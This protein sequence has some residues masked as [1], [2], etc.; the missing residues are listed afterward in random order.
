MTPPNLGQSLSILL[1]IEDDNEL[2]GLTCPATGLPVWPLIRVAVLRTIMSDWLF[3][4]EPLSSLGSNVDFVDLAKNAAISSIHNFGYKSNTQRNIL[5]QSTGLGNYYQD[6]LINDRLIGY[7]TAAFPNQTVVY[8]DKP[9]ER[10]Q[11]K[12]SF[13]LVLHKS[14]RNIINKL[15]SK[16]TV[17]NSHR[18]LARR[19]VNRAAENASAKFGYVFT[20]ERLLSLINTLASYLAV[21]PHASET[22][23]NWFAKQ[24]FRLLLKED[25]CYGGSGISIIHAAKLCGMVVA[26]YQHGAISK[27]H[28]GYNVAD[29]LATSDSFK[30]VL[31]DYLLTYGN[32]WSKQ[33]NMPVQKIAIGNPH[34][35]ETLG[36]LGQVSHRRNQVLILGDGIEAKLYLNL[37]GKILNIVKEKGLAVVFRPHPFERDKVKSST[38]PE[39]VQLDSHADIYTSLK[40][41][42]VV[43]SELSTGLFEAVGLV[44]KVLLWETDKSRF[45]FP[46]IPFKSFSTMDELELILSDK[47]S[48]HMESHTDSVTELWEPNWKQNYL[49]F[50]ESVLSK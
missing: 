37:A 13:N 4:S 5:I 29:A 26:E 39:G 23:A 36:S 6:G 14:P 45:A 16:L 1:Q 8:Q 47:D 18:S 27:G 50:V 28:D 30:A 33:S 11:D 19:V 41:S 32:W 42:S 43:I 24:G 34:L 25:A 49:R 2:V 12:Y 17:N 3:K 10:F 46:E 48:F 40:K 22:Y 9:K 15:Y 44:D 20:S 35:T 21:L 38:L 7:F 31:P